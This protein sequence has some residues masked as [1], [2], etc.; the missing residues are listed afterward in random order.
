MRNNLFPFSTDNFL[1]KSIQIFLQIKT[2]LNDDR[3]LAFL[4][5]FS[6]LNDLLNRTNEVE[7]AAIAIEISKEKLGYL[8]TIAEQQKFHSAFMQMLLW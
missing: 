4:Q 8:R 5:R 3:I 6:L 2:R 1:K 7:T